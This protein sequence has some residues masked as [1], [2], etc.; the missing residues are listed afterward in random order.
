MPRSRSQVR[1]RSRQPYAS[2]A[3]IGMAIQTRNLGLR[4]DQRERGKKKAVFHF[5]ADG[6]LPIMW[7][8]LFSSSWQMDS[9]S[10]IPG[11]QRIVL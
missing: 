6:V 2:A 4:T 5:F 9:I 7:T 3:Q 10:S 11:R 8:E 1:H